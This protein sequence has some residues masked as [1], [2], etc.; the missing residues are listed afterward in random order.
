MNELQAFLLGIIQGLTEF[1]PVSSSGHLEIGHHL[2]GIKNQNNLLF[3]VVVHTATVLS[4]VVVFRKDLARLITGL[5]SFTWEPST[6]Y[7]AKLVVSSLPVIILG[8]FFK[9]TIENLFSGN[10]LLVGSMLMVTALLLF[11]TTFAKKGQ[12][13]ISFFH[14]ILIGFSQALAVIPGISRSGATIATGLLLKNNKEETARFAFLMVL[15]PVLGAM[16]YDI[17]N[18]EFSV[19][20]QTDLIPLLIGF[21]S[22]FIAGLIACKWMI[23]VVKKGKLIYFAIYCFCIGLIAIFAA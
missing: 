19:S 1:L 15:I 12:E 3:A 6:K 17:V 22:A 20:I 16:G 4:T 5:F 11:L 21:A 14:A 23:R 2:L 9:N 8:L 18:G 13:R 10:L 7:I